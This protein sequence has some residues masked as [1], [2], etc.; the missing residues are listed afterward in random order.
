ML[1]TFAIM[2]A[3]A[4]SLQ[5]E[6]QTPY[7][8]GPHP[9]W[10]RRAPESLGLDPE[11]LQAAIDFAIENET[12]FPPELAEVADVRDLSLTVP[13]TWAREPFS[14]PIGPFEPRAAA[15]GLIVKN[16]FIVAEWG[17]TGEVDMTFSISKTFLSSTAGLAFDQGKLNPDEAVIET[18]DPPTPDFALAHNAPITWDQM[19]RQTSGWIGTLWGKPW[20]ADRPRGEEPWSDLA[21][22]PPVPGEAYE[23]NDVRVNALA[24]ALTHLWNRPLPDVLKEGVMD[25]IGA[26]DTWHWEGYENSVIDL[27][28]EDVTVVSGGGHWGGGMFI[29]AEDLARLGLLGLRRGEWDGERILSK[30]WIA[31]ATTPTGPEPG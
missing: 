19:L 15:N 8:P 24:L 18:I 16:G 6:A 14:S 7:T 4:L 1:K 2:T 9:D 23:Y 11:K 13:L 20:W 25:P 27:G 5:A 17:E 30:A 12:A 10:E 28:G 3:L 29:S 22:G 26:S 21:A 31:R